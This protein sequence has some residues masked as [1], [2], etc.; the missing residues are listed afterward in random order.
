MPRPLRCWAVGLASSQGMVVNEAA[1]MLARR[2]RTGQRRVHFI[3]AFD[4]REVGLRDKRADGRANDQ[5]GGEG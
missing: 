4:A 2:S 5:I 3:K 1:P